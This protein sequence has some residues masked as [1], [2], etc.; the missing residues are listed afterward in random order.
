M[1]L[2]MIKRKI[3]YSKKKHFV[4]AF[5]GILLLSLGIGY[6]F[7]HSSLAING[8]S[9]F[10]RST[11]DIHLDNST[12]N[13][14][15]GS[16]TPITAPSATGTNLSFSVRLENQGD[17]YSFTIDVVNSGTMNASLSGVTLTPT[18]T[19][20]QSKY[21]T[22]EVT[23]T[24]GTP[25]VIGDTINAGSSKTIKVKAQYNTG[26]DVEE[27]PIIDESY[28]FSIQLDYAQC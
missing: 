24:D 5:L 23:N 21:L 26:L 15:N 18:L 13:V 22:F 8:T 1:N 20:E 6:S 19:T 12:I 28:D 27:Y 9:M 2:K 10:K 7:L 16:I 17:C 14:D 25:L 4:Y 11:W 3:K